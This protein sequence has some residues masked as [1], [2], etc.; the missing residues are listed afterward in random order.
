MRV[1]AEQKEGDQLEKDLGA[2]LRGIAAGRQQEYGPAG[3]LALS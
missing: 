1:K 2:D 3:R